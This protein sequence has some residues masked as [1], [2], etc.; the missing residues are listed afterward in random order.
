MKIIKLILLFCFKLFLLSDLL[1]VQSL[2]STTG[3]NMHFG[4]LKKALKLR[5]SADPPKNL[6]ADD[7]PEVPIY[8]Q[9][10][11]K[12]FNY[13]KKSD[14]KS[15]KPKF[16]FKNDAYAKQNIGGN[17]AGEDDQVINIFI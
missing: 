12:Y 2:K 8:Y 9:G 14:N 17:L 11:L 4:I 15:N 1:L 13:V 7:L 3:M 16:F 6:T 10:W 5:Q